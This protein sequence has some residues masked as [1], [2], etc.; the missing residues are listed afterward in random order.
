[1]DNSQGRPYL[2]KQ[3]RDRIELLYWLDEER[4]AARLAVARAAAAATAQAAR[5]PRPPAYSV[6]TLQLPDR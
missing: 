3:A 6:A 4:K 5:S 2:A 1:M